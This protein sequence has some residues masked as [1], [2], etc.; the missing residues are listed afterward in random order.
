MSLPTPERRIELAGALNFRDL[1]GYRT[2]DGGRV[3]WRRVFRSDSLGPLTAADVARLT[4]EL[5]LVS[6][7]DLRSTAEIA[8]QGRGALVD[9][10]VDYHHVPLF[11]TENN[12]GPRRF[13][14]LHEAYRRMLT[15]SAGPIAA[16]LRIIAEADT[17]PVVFHCVAGKDRTGVV[18]AVLRGLRGVTDDDIVTDYALTQEVLPRMMERWRADTNQLDEREF[19]IHFLQAEAATMRRLLDLVREDHGSLERYAASGGISPELVA[20][21][22]AHLVEPA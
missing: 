2:E 17:H 5:G 12:S 16:V 18:A 20:A 15:R 14:P 10:A 21:L 6:V 13:P 22:R 7:I 8:K 19:P 9:A 1:G 11:E 4:D 3:R